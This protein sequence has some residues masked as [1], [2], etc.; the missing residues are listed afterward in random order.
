MP[1][2][3]YGDYEILQFIQMFARERPKWYD[4]AA[5]S[6]KNPDWWHPGQGQKAYVK[7]GIDICKG[8]PV[9]KQCLTHALTKG[10]EDGTWGATS[11]Q[12]IVWRVEGLTAAEAY[13]KLMRS[14]SEA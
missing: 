1:D 2:F 10:Y 4:K 13:S 11:D 5:C 14:E 8:C 6:G 9:R 12:R 3:S 7:R